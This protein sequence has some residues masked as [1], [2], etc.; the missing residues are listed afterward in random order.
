[1]RRSLLAILVFLSLP[2]LG[3]RIQELS[4]ELW[5]QDD[6]YVFITEGIV[7]FFDLCRHGII[8]EI[9]FSYRLPTGERYKL[10]I[11][12]E[13]VL[14]DGAP[15]PVRLSTEEGNL[16]LRIGD[17]NLLVS[18]PVVYT[19][20]YRA[21]RALRPYGEEVEFY[22]N[23]VGHAWE[24]PIDHARV[25]ARLPSGMPE[26][27]VRIMGYQG[28]RGSQEPFMLSWTG[29]GFLGETAGLAPGE[30]VT[31][32]VRLPEGYVRL[33]GAW[34]GFLW[35]LQD[36]AY[37]GIPV[38]VLLGMTALWCYRG[39]DPRKGTIAPAFSP[40]KGIGPAEAGTLVDDRMD[41]R[42]LT[43]TIV[44]LAVK[45]H[46][47]IREVWEDGEDKEPQDYELI[48]AEGREPKTPF[49][50]ALLSA[51]LG[52]AESRRLS[53]LNY[54]LYEQVPGLTTRLYMDLTE[55]GY[56]S[57]NPE[58]VRGLYRG[59]GI[60]GVV[61]GIMLGALT[62]SLY[63]G[64]ALGVSGLIVGG[65]A[66][67][68]PKKSRQGMAALREVLGLWEYIRRA[69]VE[70]LEFA[71]A[72]RH[73]EE[74]LPYALAL[75]LTEVWTRKFAGLL[76]RP[77]DWYEGRFPTFTPEKLPFRL[78]AF[79]RAAQAA[80]QTSPRSASHKGWRGGSGFGGGF[81]GGGMGGGG[82]RAW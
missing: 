67:A 21:A 53:D 10:R 20:R 74:L 77:P 5:I 9:P 45:G 54:K 56:Y 51:L 25:V 38:L 24:W 42:D 29:D 75:G 35:F 70:R 17:P 32:A 71:A 33:P 68:M 4:V 81:S 59:L 80:A 40:P 22:W 8:R 27:A 14:A 69:E 79:Q 41:L 57:G 60:G 50:E 39:R 44:G 28:V 52:G 62:A 30:G 61:L 23:A 78:L 76:R 6:G 15:V 19:I 37:A 48:R 73:F 63:L 7:V 16:V 49:E 18:G 64:A 26:D 2:A 55:R 58:R 13:E 66:R 43:A 11:A 31:V 12:V 34:Q 46:L 72:E 65:F 3:E 82:G 1:M 36:N 47:R